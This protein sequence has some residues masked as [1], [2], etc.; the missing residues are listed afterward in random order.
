MDF[1]IWL[2]RDSVLYSIKMLFDHISLYVRSLIFYLMI[3]VGFAIVMG[4]LFLSLG[5]SFNTIYIWTQA[6]YLSVVNYMPQGSFLLT[7]LGLL[8]L[9]FIRAGFI[10]MLLQLH[11]TGSS[12]INVMYEHFSD[13]LFFFFVAFIYYVAVSL[14]LFL[15]IIPGIYIAIRWSLAFYIFVDKKVGIIQS[16]RESWKL[17]EHFEWPL[18]ALLMIVFALSSAWLLTLFMTDLMFIYAYRTIDTR[19][20]ELAASQIE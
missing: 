4:L 11:D 1:Q 9:S 19:H 13:N 12:A 15:L 16:L 10:R 18:F 14:G 8:V 17:T 6:G 7:L 2:V 5:I 20:H 3:L